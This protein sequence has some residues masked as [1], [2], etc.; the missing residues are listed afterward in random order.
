MNNEKTTLAVRSVSAETRSRLTELKA[1]T[2]LT[3]ASLLD[4]AVEGLWA[5]YVADGHEL[6][7]GPWDIG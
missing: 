2:R 7:S 3:Y 5:D 4:D 6:P 1:Y